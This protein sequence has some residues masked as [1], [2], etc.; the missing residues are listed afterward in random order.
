MPEV[1]VEYGVFFDGTKNNMY[2]VDFYR[3]YKKFLEK[4][5]EDII[6]SKGM[7]PRPSSNLEDYK[8]IQEY[9]AAE[10]NPGKNQTIMVMLQK[11]ILSHGVRYFDKKSNETKKNNKYDD[12]IFWW[13]TKISDHAEKV[14]DYLLDVK[15]EEKDTLGSHSGQN[16]FLY[17][18]ILPNDEGEGSYTNGETNISRLYKLY[19]G[20]DL[21]T[22]TD[23][24]PVTRFKVYASGSGTNDVFE[25]ENYDSDSIVGLG[26]GVGDTGVKAHI[27]YTCTKMVEQ[28]RTAS[29][30]I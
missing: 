14:F 12:S 18:E 30:L 1:K 23:L 26:L 17:K 4:P 25:K 2:N 15:N 13:Q 7:E 24:A 19:N 9:I 21:K 29:I 27:I 8:T 5:C 20:D 22:K 11:Q 10:P 3:N 28:L 16:K 6:N